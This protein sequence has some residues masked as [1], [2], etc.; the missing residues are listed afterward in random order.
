MQ[1]P[2]CSYAPP[3]LDKHS[4]EDPQRPQGTEPQRETG[5]LHEHK[6]G[7][8]EQPLC[9]R[10]APQP[11]WA[12]HSLSK[13]RKELLPVYAKST[14]IMHSAL[15]KEGPKSPCLEST[16][17]EN[18]IQVLQLE[19]SRARSPVQTAI[20]WMRNEESP[21]WSMHTHNGNQVA[22]R[23]V[24]DVLRITNS[25]NHGEFT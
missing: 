19:L 16:A 14:H 11:L 13:E 25:S 10:Q 20:P 2:L 17:L 7:S 22:I 24:K 4:K 21:G 23:R 15:Q 9:L 5:A 6:A 18:T 12:S 1:P 3:V 8:G